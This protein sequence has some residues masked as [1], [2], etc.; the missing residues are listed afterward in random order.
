MRKLRTVGPLAT[1]AATVLLSF[2]FGSPA[3]AARG[4]T[5]E[6][7]CYKKRISDG[8]TH[9]PIIG[10][11]TGKTEDLAIAAAKKHANDQMPPGYRGVHCD[12]K[13]TKRG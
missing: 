9:A 4:W 8:S 3:Q 10:H 7:Q 1:V 5:A 12:T 2:G 11:G 13:K 6:V